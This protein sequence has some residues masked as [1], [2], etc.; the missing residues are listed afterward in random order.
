MCL[1]D[2]IDCVILRKNQ[3]GEKLAL[4]RRYF[5]KGRNYRLWEKILIVSSV[6][7]LHMYHVYG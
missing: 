7:A 6:N 2:E 5:K 4:H 1:I 3:T